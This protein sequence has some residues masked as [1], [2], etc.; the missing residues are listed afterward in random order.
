MMLVL[1]VMMNLRIYITFSV[2]ALTPKRSGQISNRTGTIYRISQSRSFCLKRIIWSF[3]QTMPFIKF[4]K[5][6]YNNWKSIFV[7]LQKE[8]NI[9]K[10]QGLKSKLKIKYETEKNI[11]KK[12]LFQKK[13]VLI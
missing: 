6:F 1:F 10:I 5:L 13:W 4:I 8:P 2:N 9:S 11:N 7:G 3:I 12:N